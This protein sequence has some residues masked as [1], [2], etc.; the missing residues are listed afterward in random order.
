[1]SNNRKPL[2]SEEEL[3]AYRVQ[4]DLWKD[5]NCCMPSDWRVRYFYEQLI[6]EGKLRVVEEV[7]D[8]GGRY[9]GYVCSGCSSKSVEWFKYCPGCGNKIKR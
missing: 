8:K 9:D 5:L 4:Y 6:T 3:R 2:L 1:M 7:E